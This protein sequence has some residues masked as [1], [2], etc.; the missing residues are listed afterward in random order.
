MTIRVKKNKTR[1][2]VNDPQI[3]INNIHV[4][5]VQKAFMLIHGT[6]RDNSCFIIK[7]E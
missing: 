1:M 6:I 3:S 4:M 5:H 7:R 2:A